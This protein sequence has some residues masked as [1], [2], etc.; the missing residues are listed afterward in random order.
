VDQLA[1][2]P[3]GFVPDN[4]IPAKHLVPLEEIMIN[5]KGMA[6]IG[7]KIRQEYDNLVS[8]FGSELNILLDTKLEDLE[9]MTSKEVVEG[10]KRMREGKVQLTPGYDGVYG[11]VSVSGKK[12]SGTIDV[13]ESKVKSP[14]QASLF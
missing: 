10:I 4:A 14:Q 2:R 9:K 13:V 3:E 6:S 5:V 12:I 7:Q 11:K 1:D 8:V